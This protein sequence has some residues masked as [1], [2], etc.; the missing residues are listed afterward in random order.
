MTGLG[1]DRLSIAMVGTRGLPA[2][3]GGFETCIEEVGRRLASR[4]H[5]V[6]VYCRG[7]RD[8][9]TAE[10]YLGMHLVHLPAVRVRALETL[11]HTG[12]SAMHVLG[13]PVDVAIV[14]NAANSPWLPLL[15]AA[16]IPVATHVD[17]LEWQRAK[18]GPAGKKYYRYA[19]SMSVRFSDALI[20]DAV[21]IQDYYWKSFRAPTRL[22][23][24]GAPQLELGHF[25]RLGELE[26]QARR[27]HL[28]VARLEPENNLE[29]II[30]GYVL[31]DA[32]HPLIVVG[33]APYAE[34]YRR[35]LHSLGDDRVHFLGSLWDQEL[36]NQLYAN[37]LVYWH[38]HSVGGTNP[39]LLRAMGAGAPVNAFDVNFNREVLLGAGQYFTSALDV[40]RL[41][42]AA[43]AD[44]AAARSRG[45]QGRLRSREYDW[46]DVA[47]KY[48]EL[49]EDL[50]NGSLARTTT[51]RRGD[52][53]QAAAAVHHE[54]RR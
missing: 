16:K 28:A 38:G 51:R 43:E 29:K 22:I 42:E 40:M 21:G 35:L 34:E 13:H 45:M 18:W 49:C 17:G 4:G 24:Y 12:L 54:A 37:A 7:E 33:S 14:F 11:S 1:A 23:A 31:S 50:A 25:E 48:E 15:R 36:L 10:E 47:D 19:E 8:E 2:R 53:G 3:Y 20:A 44:P 26:L 9:N 27:Y 39:S 6:V 30:R 41:V 5:R 52:A 46:D 32:V